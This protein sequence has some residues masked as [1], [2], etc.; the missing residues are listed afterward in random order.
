MKYFKVPISLGFMAL[1]LISKFK[2]RNFNDRRNESGRGVKSV[3]K[4]ND[5]VA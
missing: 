4:A 3:Y 1:N 2:R 5:L